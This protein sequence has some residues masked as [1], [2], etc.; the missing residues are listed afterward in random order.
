[1]LDTCLQDARFA[2]RLL[3]KTP[4]FTLTAVLSL[5]VGVGA[6][7]TIFSIASAMLLRPMPGLS[8]PDRL[9]DIGRSRRPGEFDTVSYPNYKDIRDRATTIQDIYAYQIEPHPMSLGGNG[10][11][12]RV[13]GAVVSANY[14]SVLG[15][16][17][18]RG[19]LLRADDD[20]AVGGSPVAVISHE[21]WVRRFAADAGI[22]GRE[23]KVNGFPFGVVGIA[24]RGFQG[25]TVLKA[26]LWVPI[27]M[28]A[29]A[30]PARSTTLLTSRRSTWLFMG[31]RLADGATVQQARA[32]LTSIADG[33]AKEY[34]DVNDRFGLVALPVASVPGMVN[35]VAGFLG[36]LM[37]IVGLLL[38]IAC[39]NLAG[40]L[41][42]R[43]AARS[44]EIAVRLAIGA[45]R[46]RLVRQL[47]T[48]TAVLFL[49]G[50]VAGLLL[51]QVL[52][53]LLLAVIPQLPVPLAIDI[54]TDWRVV[55]FTAA[56]SLVAAILCGLAPALQASRTNLVPSLKS[57][58]LDGRPSRLRLRNIFVVGQVTLSLVL[59]IAAGLFL[60][61]LQH[62]G[63]AP[64]GFDARNVDVVSL[65]LSLAGYGDESGEIFLRQLLDRIRQLPNVQ[66]ASATVDL[67]LDGGRM[68]LGDF[69]ISGV[70]LPSGRQSLDADWNVIE[71]GFFKTLGMPLLRGRDF[72]DGDGAESPGVAIVNQAFVRQYL[73]GREAVGTSIDTT[74]GADEKRRTRVIVGVAPDAQLMSIGEAA[75]PYIY[76]PRAQRPMERLALVVRT[77]GRSAIPSI[78]QLIRE[79]NPNLP[80]NEALSLEA[81]TAF[82]LIPQRIAASV[83]GTLGIVGLALAAIGI[84]GVTSYAVS[85]RAREIGIRVALGADQGAVLRLML[86]QGA[87][88]AT[89][90]VMLG[91]ALAA[92]GSQVIKSLLFGVTALDPLTFAGA[93][94]LFTVIALIATY[95]PARKALSIDPMV[96]L[97]ND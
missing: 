82:G 9:V 51:S 17:P 38:L 60:R 95:V 77:A 66:S 75:E 97:R 44:R 73:A 15:A 94:L 87:A 4:L 49:A 36:V 35:T 96:A 21:L 13:Y 10:E 23:I 14:F 40:M 67:P 59:V 26:D 89:T 90:G 18:E 29:Q 83:A 48:E 8:A 91:L 76:V 52:T 24:P 61:A 80:V 64:T 41:L 86:R 50:G 25:T 12:E 85:R 57:D 11:A 22:V 30:M 55:A 34:P 78:R 56:A 70:P 45:G 71:P 58:A 42:A 16:L 72:A 39:V 93:A 19:R 20:R 31:G 32:E 47:L 3:R 54:T 28:V 2:V 74:D 79:M 7:S 92:A 5:A 46:G 53:R 81:V 27:S 6:N 63:N 69:S 37:G 68:G 33:L 43:G 84:Y 62:A 88:L 65:D 1:M